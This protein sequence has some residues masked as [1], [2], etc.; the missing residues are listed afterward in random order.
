MEQLPE[1]KPK[2]NVVLKWISQVL[3]A[4]AAASLA[5][6]MFLTVADV[7]GTYFFLR[8]IEGTNE[9]VGMMLV[10][11]S[12][13]GLGWC[14]LIKGNIRITLIWDRLSRRG[15]SMMDTF[16]YLMCTFCA[17]IIAWRGSILLYEYL[18]KQ[19]GSKSAI[20][21]VL[22]WPFILV[23]VIGF[24]WATVIFVIDVY[25]SFVGVFKR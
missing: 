9:L 14:E 11:T 12:A 23:M 2:P 21:G 6:M 13:L 10:I 25:K 1:Q 7:I 24:A 22:L 4:I 8:P 19:L 16:D 17:F 18:N 5:V 15:R 20:M 3:A